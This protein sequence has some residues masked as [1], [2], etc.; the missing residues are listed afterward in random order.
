MNYSKIG[1]LVVH[2]H[3]C[4]PEKDFE[5][6]LITFCSPFCTCESTQPIPRLLASVS[7]VNGTSGQGIQAPELYTMPL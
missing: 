3:L 2:H 5:P 6:Y 7:K 4:D 1:R